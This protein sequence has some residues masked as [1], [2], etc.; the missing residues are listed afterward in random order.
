M[1]S[2]GRRA[3]SDGSTFWAGAATQDAACAELPGAGH[4]AYVRVEDTSPRIAEEPVGAIFAQFVQVGRTSNNPVG[5]ACLGPTIR[6]RLARAMGG[7]ISVESTV[8]VGSAFVVWLP[9]AP[10]D[11]LRIGRSP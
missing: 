6:R 7:E 11:A 4:R 10:F 5:G 8:G 9:V 2:E 1:V 3:R